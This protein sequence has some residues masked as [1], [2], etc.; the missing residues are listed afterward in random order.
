MRNFK[1]IIFAAAALSLGFA[2]TACDD[3]DTTVVNEVAVPV[4]ELAVPVAG[5]D[6]SVDITASVRPTVSAAPPG[7]W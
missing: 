2:M 3:D 4:T 1:S 7:S 5:Q 6:W